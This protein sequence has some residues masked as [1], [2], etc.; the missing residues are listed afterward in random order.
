[1]YSARQYQNLIIF[2]SRGAIV[3]VLMYLAFKNTISDLKTGFLGPSARIASD[4]DVWSLYDRFPGL[5][6]EV[7]HCHHLKGHC[8]GT[9]YPSEKQTFQAGWRQCRDACNDTDCQKSVISEALQRTINETWDDRL[10]EYVIQMVDSSRINVHS[11]G[12]NCMKQIALPGR[13]TASLVVHAT[14][15]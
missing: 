10:R 1:L 15:W 8:Q 9:N 12:R 3:K 11:T 7:Y 6:G 2:R 14:K 4:S 13:S 5:C